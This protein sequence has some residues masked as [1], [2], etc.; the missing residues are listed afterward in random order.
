M[1]TVATELFRNQVKPVGENLALSFVRS[2]QTNSVDDFHYD[3]LISSDYVVTGLEVTKTIAAQPAGYDS[4]VTVEKV[5]FSSVGAEEV[6]EIAEAIIAATLVAKGQKII[7]GASAATGLIF[8]DGGAADPLVKV[9]SQKAGVSKTQ[10]RIRI[11]I[12]S[13]GNVAASVNNL[14]LFINVSLA[15]YL[16]IAGLQGQELFSAEPTA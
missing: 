6:T 16:D 12:K 8:H 4:I 2:K 1:A 11:H 13:T 7:S 3:F 5:S 14:S 10:Q 9:K 15:R